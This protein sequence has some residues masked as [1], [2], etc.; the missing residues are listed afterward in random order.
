MRPIRWRGDR[1]AAAVEAAIVTPVVMA[2]IFGIVEFGFFF[3]DYLSAATAARDGVR[4]ASANPRYSG[5]AQAA[6]DRVQHSGSA[7]DYSTVQQ[8][9]VYK[10]NATNDYPIGFSSFSN[11]TTCVKFSW[12]GSSFQ[13]IPGTSWPSTSQVA[14]V[15]AGG[16]PDRIGVYIKLRHDAVTGLVFDSLTISQYSVMSLEPIPVT[17]GCK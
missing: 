1:G 12:T 14:C 5:F 7:L 13:P 4:L 17:N 11:C 2:M 6:A 16:P 10:A 3:K 8:L 9:W 15:G